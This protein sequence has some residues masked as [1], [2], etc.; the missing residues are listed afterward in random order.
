MPTQ[1][2]MLPPNVGKTRASENQ[3]QG[4]TARANP[5]GPMTLPAVGLR[6]TAG[7]PRISANFQKLTAGAARCEFRA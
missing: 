3:D 6:P 7:T 2:T 1:Y 4:W 5:A